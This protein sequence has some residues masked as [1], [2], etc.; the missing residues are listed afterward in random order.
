MER[1]GADSIEAAQT[2]AYRTRDNKDYG[3]DEDERREEWI[4]TAEPFGVSPESVGELVAAAHP[5]SPAR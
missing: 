5:A 1:H 4:A 2:A 3:V